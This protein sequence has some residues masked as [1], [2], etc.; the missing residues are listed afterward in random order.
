[1]SEWEI[2]SRKRREEGS[3]RKSEGGRER[4]K[5]RMTAYMLLY[6]PVSLSVSQSA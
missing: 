2:E 4:E 5:V 3:G 1:M 6:L